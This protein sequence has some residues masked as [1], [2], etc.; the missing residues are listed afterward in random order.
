MQK[1]PRL[2][3]RYAIAAGKQLQHRVTV[4]PNPLPSDLQQEL[5]TFDTRQEQLEQFEASVIL[6][7]GN[8]DRSSDRLIGRTATVGRAVLSIY[9]NSPI[10]LE[11]QEEQRVRDAENFLSL[12]PANL[13]NLTHIEHTE[14]YV[15]IG[16]ILQRIKQEPEM[17]QSIERLG[18]TTD[19]DYLRRLY[20][21]YGQLLGITE[22][23]LEVQEKL[24]AWLD[25]YSKLMVLAAYHGLQE[26]SIE[27]LIFDPY[28]EQLEEQR[29]VKRQAEQRRK[30]KKATTEPPQPPQS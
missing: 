23:P 25:S 21:H 22:I 17:A 13:R 20:Y 6:P 19:F 4:Y 26:P 10:P 3:L 24:D 12:Y 30:E 18:M 7:I 16:G 29:K 1:P 5:K 11:P 14:E 8:I 9:E 15:A 2:Q 28:Y 27:S